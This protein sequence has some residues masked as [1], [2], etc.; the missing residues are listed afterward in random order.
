[1]IHDIIEN[2]ILKEMDIYDNLGFKAGFIIELFTL[3]CCIP[4]DW[5]EK[6]LLI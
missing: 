3:K 2:A 4:N 1:M 5:M 6:N